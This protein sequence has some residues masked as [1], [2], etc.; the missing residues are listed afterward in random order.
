MS[1]SQYDVTMLLQRAKLWRIEAAVATL[2][3]MRAFC[4]A[5]AED[6]ERRVQ[7]SLSVPILDQNDH[8]PV[9]SD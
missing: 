2:E 6:C 7:L 5:Q 3:A 1:G 4:L 9:R 8:P